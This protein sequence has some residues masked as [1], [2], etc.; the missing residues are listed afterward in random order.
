MGTSHI[1]VYQDRDDEA[2]KSRLRQRLGKYQVGQCIGFRATVFTLVH[3]T[4][5]ASVAHALQD[6]ARHAASMLPRHRMGLDFAVDKALHLVAQ[7]LVFGEVVDVVHSGAHVIK[8]CLGYVY[9]LCHKKLQSQ[10]STYM[11][12]TP[13]RVSSIGAFKAVESPNAKTRRVSAG[14]ITPSSHKR[15][16]A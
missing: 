16:L 4:K 15:A 11:R 8:K 13:K 7:G 2:R 6:I 3:Q 1:G 14:S 5:K 10:F 9:G 12:K